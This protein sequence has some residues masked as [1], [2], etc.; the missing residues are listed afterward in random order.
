MIAFSDPERSSHLLVHRSTL[1]G[2]TGAV[3]RRHDLSLEVG[4]AAEAIFVERILVG[5]AE[6]VVGVF[7]EGDAVPGF[8][9]WVRLRRLEYDGGREECEGCGGDGSPAAAR[10]RHPLSHLDAERVCEGMWGG[11][12]RGASLCTHRDRTG[13][14]CRQRR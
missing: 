7:N 8:A 12:T 10:R 13:T 2:G 1:A 11:S 3:Q 14:G 5:G 9:A 4:V 6:L